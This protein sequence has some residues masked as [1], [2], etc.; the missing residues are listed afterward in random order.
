LAEIAGGDPAENAAALR[1]LLGGAPGRYRDAVI[2]SGAAALLVAGDEP[3]A[4]LPQLAQRVA[5]ALD[6][7]SAAATLEALVRVS[8]A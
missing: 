4:V 5:A 8:N 3:R 1:E 6:D 2:Y 7:G